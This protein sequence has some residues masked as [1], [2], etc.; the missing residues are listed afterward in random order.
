MKGPQNKPK[1]YWPIPLIPFLPVRVFRG[2]CLWWSTYA[3]NWKCWKWW[4]TRKACDQLNG[5][6]CWTCAVKE[7]CWIT[8]PEL[9][10]DF[11]ISVGSVL[12]ILTYNLG[13]RRVSA[14]FVP[15]LLTAEQKDARVSVA[16]DL[17]GFVRND[18]NFIY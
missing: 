9:S 10:D 7:N 16:K 3:I 18:N 6:K 12:S 14:K 17:L 2:P 1:S 8:I 15:K 11:N 5:Q 13:M 4:A